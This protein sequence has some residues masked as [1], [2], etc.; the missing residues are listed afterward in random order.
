MD[1]HGSPG[2]TEGPLCAVRAT[3][4]GASWNFSQEPGGAKSLIVHLFA[5]L[6]GREKMVAASGG[7][8]HAL[9]RELTTFKTWAEEGPPIG[10]LYHYPNITIT[11]SCRLAGA[12]APNKIG[13]QIYVQG[14]D[15]P[16]GCAPFRSAKPWK[17]RRLCGP[18]S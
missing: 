2:A 17:R 1:T 14:A 8:R 12:P 11:R 16:D 3:I 9:V 7:I 13:E 6:V 18:A 5:A 4:S 15:D 10:T